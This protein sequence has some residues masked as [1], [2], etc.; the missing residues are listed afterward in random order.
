VDSNQLLFAGD[1]PAATISSRVG[2]GELRQIARGL[3]TVDLTTDPT[4]FVHRNWAAIAGRLY[5]DAVITDRSAITGGPNDGYLYL[6]HNA[7]E[8]T[9]EL[10]GLTIL[11]RTGAAPQPDDFPIPGGL[12][13]ASRGRALAEN[14]RPSRSR[15][16]RPARTLTTD[17]L[18]GW[19]NRLCQIDKEDK[20]SR[21]RVEAE[22]IA[23]IVGA[24]ADGIK[25]LGH[26]IGAALQTQTAISND[27]AL[28]A[29]QAGAPYDPDRLARF[30]LLV[31][32]LRSAS[33]QHRA[34]IPGGHDA[35]AV[36]AFYEAYFSNF[37]EGTE[38][39]LDEARKLVFEDEVPVDRTADGHDVIGTYRIVADRGEMSIIPVTP[40]EMIDLLR[41]RHADLM[42][43]RPD[44][45]PG[46]FKDVSN[47]AG[48]T[49]FVAPDLVIGTLNEGFQRLAALDTAWER[50]AYTAFLIAEVHPFIDGNG[51]MARVM[52]NAELVAGNQSKIIVPIGAR[53]NY[54]AAL[55]LLSRQ[56]DPSSFIKTMRFLHDYTSQIDWTSGDVAEADLRST[57][58]F[59]D[60]RDADTFHRITLLRPVA[61]LV[62]PDPDPDPEASRNV[63]FV[64][65][66]ERDGRMVGG[67]E[68]RRPRG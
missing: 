41:S 59:D 28:N 27:P 42:A 53:N 56:D 65:P 68:I 7:R 22:A 13:L 5:P 29:R 31:A 62:L 37:I 60:E 50:A 66:Y 61:D 54:L 44:K 46:M 25:E 48:N 43:G 32:A 10:P 6:A 58:G 33:P 45:D 47:Q 18:T 57:N 26:L 11:T 12:H 3:Y 40:Q 64:E 21:Y 19:V 1:I 38:F 39:T 9:T 14:T 36:Q 15:G 24:P 16:G 34:G 67:Y 52:M 23:D 20:L 49:T 35:F 30:D 17:E 63:R 4:T 8:R 2:R 55:R 51:R